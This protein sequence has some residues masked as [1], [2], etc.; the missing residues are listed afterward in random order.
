MTKDQSIRMIYLMKLS[1]KGC[2]QGDQNAEM[3]GLIQMSVKHQPELTREEREIRVE[4]EEDEVKKDKLTTCEERNQ[5]KKFLYCEN[6]EG[7]MNEFEVSDLSELSTLYGW[8]CHGCKTDDNKLL[9]WAS[10]AQVGEYTEHRLGVMIRIK[11]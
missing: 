5:A 3:M 8:M 10:T 6:Q 2:L 11:D 4:I 9:K 1:A 7:G